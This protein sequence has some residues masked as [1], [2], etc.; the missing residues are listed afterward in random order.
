MKKYINIL[1]VAVTAIFC[2]SACQKKVETIDTYHV[3][4]EFRNSGAK[5]LT[6]DVTLNPKDSI[7][8]D[9]TITSQEDMDYV[10]IQRN[11]TRIDTFR[12]PASNK[13]SFTTI[14]G[15]MADSAA[16]EYTYRIMGRTANARYLG[17]GGKIIKVTITPDFHFWSFRT[18]MVPDTTAKVNKCYYAT[19]TG[20]IYN[21]TE[22]AA[23]SALIDFGYYCDT[24]GKASAS[25]SDDLKHTFYALSSAQ[26]QIA[27]YDI[28]TW[29]KNA[30]VFKV[31]TGVNFVTLLTS[32]ANIDRYIKNNMTSGT[33]SKVNKLDGGSIVGFKTAAGK[34]GAIQ[35]RYANQNSPA[36]DTEIQVDVKVQK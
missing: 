10:E 3:T 11:G 14:K 32:S 25:A 31:I 17:D 5:Y 15:Y 6:G 7:Y 23:N 26:P 16:G 8:F 27:F 21:Y 35:L 4:I 1:S 24:V 20:N 33:A 9:F 22:G 12:L 18:L 36:K 2:F 13:R 34:Y 29:T 28:S 19:T 30:T